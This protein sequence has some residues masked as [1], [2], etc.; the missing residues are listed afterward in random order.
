MKKR[1]IRQD[2]EGL[3]GKIKLAEME[4]NTELVEKLTNQFN[5][6]SKDLI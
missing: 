3:S 4:N 6:I 2:L 1:K 5:E